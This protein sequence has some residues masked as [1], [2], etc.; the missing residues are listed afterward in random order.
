MELKALKKISYFKDQYLE[1]INEKKQKQQHKHRQDSS[2]GSSKPS[3]NRLSFDVESIKELS[4]ADQVSPKKPD[5]KPII[6]NNTLTK[7]PVETPNAMLN[8]NEVEKEIA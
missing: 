3:S 1:Q 2:P 4:S 8:L 6:Q 5:I 7:I